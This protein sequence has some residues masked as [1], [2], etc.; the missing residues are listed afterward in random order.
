L[1]SLGLK[2]VSGDSLRERTKW[3]ELSLKKA[4]ENGPWGREKE[5]KYIEW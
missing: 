1:I 3:R 2:R 4:E 5:K